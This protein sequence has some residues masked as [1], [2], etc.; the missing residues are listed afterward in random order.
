[1]TTG[2]GAT[3]QV[4]VVV[5]FLIVTSS[6]YVIRRR[7]F[8]IFWF[9]HHLFIVFFAILMTHGTFCFIQTNFGTCPGPSF[10]KYWVGF[11]AMY[12][13]ER[14][15]RE[16][17]GRLPTHISKVV[18]HPSKVC[19]VQIKKPSCKIRSGQYIFLCCPEVARYEVRIA[20]DLQS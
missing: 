8:E 4:L 3:G 15:V 1:M 19:E 16:L 7:Y 18:M 2:P 20:V 9:T 14:V 17:R 12:L 11:G 10:W 6:I 13:L 5:L